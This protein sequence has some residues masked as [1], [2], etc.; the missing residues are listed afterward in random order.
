MTGFGSASGAEAGFHVAV[1]IRSVNQR[2]LKLS[3]RVPED[4]SWL[5]EIAEARL[6]ERFGR[7]TIAVTVLVTPVTQADHYEIDGRLLAKLYREVQLL[8]HE[9]HP[10]EEV[11]LKDLLPLEG[12]LRTAPLEEAERGP[13]E[14]LVEQVLERAVQTLQEMQEREGRHLVGELDRMLIGI[15]TTLAQVAELL[16]QAGEQNRSRYQK[17]LADFLSGTGVEVQAAEVLREVA[18]LAEKADVTEEVGRLQGHLKHY[19]R[20]L[21]N[22]GRVGR[23]LDFL[24]QELLREANTMAAKVSHLELATLVVELKTDIDRVREQTQNI[25]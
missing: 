9:L 10:G 23:K 8:T 13:L 5:Q 6:R 18:I 7:G 2:Y 14:R 15:E 3:L 20:A 25:E 24:A 4:L 16:P 17:R 11:R 22:G 21:R 12:V 19:R 1:E